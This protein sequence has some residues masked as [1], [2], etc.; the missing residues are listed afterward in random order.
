MTK[1]F[2]PEKNTSGKLVI[3]SEAIDTVEALARAVKA[4]KHKPLVITSAN[5]DEKEQEIMENFDA[6]YDGEQ[7]DDYDVII[8]TE[9]LAE[10]V[11]LH[12]ANVILNYDTPWNS[13]RLMQRIGRVN[14][15]GSREPKVY[16]YNFMPSAEG[17]AE[18]QLVHKA[19]TKLQSFH[20]LFGEDSKIF[21]DEESIVH[22]DMVKAIDGE[23]S[24]LQPYISVLKQYKADYPKRYTEIESAAGACW[25]IAQATHGTAYFV[26]KAPYSARLVVKT[27]SA[28]GTEAKIISPLEALEEMQVE[29]TTP[30]VPLPSSWDELS[31]SACRVYNQY[32][33]RIRQ[34]R[35]GAL[36]TKAQGIIVKL[37]EH[38]GLSPAS[39][40]LLRRARMLVDKG[41]I[42]I[43]K[44]IIFIDEELEA[45]ESRLFA[46]EQHDIDLL[47]EE[48]IGKLVAKVESKQGEA[49]IILGTIK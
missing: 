19:H 45:K 28:T 39:Q 25:Q 15:I 5:R 26:V 1:L 7:K 30:S 27:D 6:N 8:T 33:V 14:R 47:L 41:S 37:Q 4:K 22:Y 36:R 2:D 24:P 42:D 13:T 35:A 17:D 3:F 29:P 10:G 16:V 48:G 44:R 18:I 46:L 23:E 12:R 40:S 20:V 21:S 38:N 9:V 34:S 32:F 31:K 43:I 11:N 49:S